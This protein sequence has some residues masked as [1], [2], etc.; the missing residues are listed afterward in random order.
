MFTSF[1]STRAKKTY[2]SI[3]YLSQHCFPWKKDPGTQAARRVY[4][5]LYYDLLFVTDVKAVFERSQVK[6]TGKND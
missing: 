6:K 5:T 4:S 3:L 2:F 1:V